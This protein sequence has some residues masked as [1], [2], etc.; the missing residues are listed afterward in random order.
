MVSFSK[1]NIGGAQ[2]AAY[3][4]GT[5]FLGCG[6]F[7]C[8]SRY[9]YHMRSHVDH[10]Y[11]LWHTITLGLICSRDCKLLGVLKPLKQSGYKEH[12]EG[13]QSLN[14]TPPP[15]LPRRIRARA[16]D[17]VRADQV[18]R[19]PVK[20]DKRGCCKLCRINARLTTNPLWEIQCATLLR[21]GKK[22]F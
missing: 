3:C 13:V 18:V 20:C 2:H 21:R 16:P 1:S 17:D 5:I 8:S 6:G 22:L 11:L 7:T 15:P 9:S 10:L 19:W 4:E 12:K 14:A